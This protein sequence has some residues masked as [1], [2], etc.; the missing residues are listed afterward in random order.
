MQETD[1]QLQLGSLIKE[2]VE[3]VTPDY[4]ISSPSSILT[5]VLD[6]L[7]TRHEQQTTRTRLTAGLC[8]VMGFPPVLLRGTPR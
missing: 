8:Q 5:A 2:A 7:S 3:A 6:P 4:S 1:W